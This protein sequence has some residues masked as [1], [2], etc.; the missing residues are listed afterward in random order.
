MKSPLK[1]LIFSTFVVLLGLNIWVFVKGISLSS[2]ISKYEQKTKE[3][4]K[5]NM[6]LETELYSINSL[7][8]T[9]SIAAQLNFSKKA[10]PYFLDNLKVALKK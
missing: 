9:S 7:K 10:E 8:H 1:M 6:E 5:V 3:L 4:K 2:D